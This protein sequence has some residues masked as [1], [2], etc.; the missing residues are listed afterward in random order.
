MSATATLEDRVSALERAVQSGRDQLTPNYLTVN[1]DGS[2]G[3]DFSGHVS[4]QGLDLPAGT[5][6]TPPSQDRVRW[7]RGSDGSVVADVTAYEVA[8]QATL[9]LGAYQDSPDT[10]AAVMVQTPDLL[11]SLI[12][13]PF[14]QQLELSAGG[15]ALILDALTPAGVNPGSIVLGN[16]LGQ[17]TLLDNNGASSFLQL[18]GA[19]NWRVCFGVVSAAG[20][21]LTGSNVQSIVH[22]GVGSYTITFANALAAGTPIVLAT[23]QT[24]SGLALETAAVASTGFGAGIFKTSTGANTDSQWAFVAIG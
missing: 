20:A 19:S 6:S 7:L 1:A 11:V 17:M 3:A 9:R 15:I 2:V 18:V 22:G 21:L 23:P 12:D 16:H 4:A 8:N 24:T 10:A 13:S 14:E 5:S